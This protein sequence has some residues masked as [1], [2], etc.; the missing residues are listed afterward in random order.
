MLKP[1]KEA[2]QG[3]SRSTLTLAENLEKEMIK[4]IGEKITEMFCKKYN[5]QLSNELCNEHR[6]LK[7]KRVYTNKEGNKVVIYC[8]HLM[9]MKDE[10][11]YKAY[12]TIIYET[13]EA[14][15][16]QSGDF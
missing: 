13:L 2:K 9:T 4:T 11:F 10:Q 14:I 5:S 7:P 8:P 6:C 1:N 12:E 15:L 16:L 3:S